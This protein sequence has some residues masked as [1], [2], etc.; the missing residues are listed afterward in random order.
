LLAY[1]LASLLYNLPPYLL[2]L[3]RPLLAEIQCL[4]NGRTAPQLASKYKNK[5]EYSGDG[6]D[7]G[8]YSDPQ[9]QRFVPIN[10]KRAADGFPLQRLLLICAVIEKR[11]Q[12]PLWSKDI[13][14]N[15]VGGLRVSEPSADLAV[16]MSIVSSALEES[17]IPG[18]A[19]IGEI[20]LGGELRGGKRVE[21]RVREAVKMGFTRIVVPSS[22][23]FKRKAVSNSG[24]PV[25]RH[26]DQ[27]FECKTIYDALLVAFANPKVASSLSRQR[28][29]SRNRN[30]DA[31]AKY[32]NKRR[33]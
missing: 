22:A 8:K 20:G 15:V 9:Q 18:T 33:F 2:S 19:F 14:L 6:D 1:L 26:D 25:A 4:V 23:G 7:S 32:A 13:Y 29:N 5:E 16:A 30:T 12:L 31:S 11:L 10:P 27:L 17:I 3:F 24:D 28:R 21:D